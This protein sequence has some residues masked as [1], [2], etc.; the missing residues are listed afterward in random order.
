M[1]AAPE[2]MRRFF[3]VSKFGVG[4]DFEIV[5]ED[6]QRVLFIDGKLGMKPTAEVQDA[7]GTVIM[8]VEGK[9]LGIPKRMTIMD[10]KGT[11]LAS[12]KA[13]I[14]PLKSRI[15]IALPDGALWVLE[16]NLIEKDYSVTT[17]DGRVALAISQKWMTVRDRYAMDVADGV[18]LAFAAAML[19]TVDAFREQR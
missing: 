17:A 15:E 7:A 11:E 5:G 10:A 19:W 2:G 16:G 8:R 9:L 1:E 14:S 18:D 6:E 4:R 12:L 13:K 3:V